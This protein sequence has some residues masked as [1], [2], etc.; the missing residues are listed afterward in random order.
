MFWMGNCIYFWS[1]LAPRAV[2]ATYPPYHSRMAG[3]HACVSGSVYM[4]SLGVRVGN[5]GP[6]LQ[7]LRS[8]SW[9]LIAASNCG[10]ADTEMRR[11]RCNPHYHHFCKTLR[12]LLK[13][14]P[15]DLKIR[16]LFFSPFIFFFFLWEADKVWDIQKQPYVKESLES[17]CTCSRKVQAFVYHI[18]ALNPV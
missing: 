2:V 3:S 16:C 8:I 7:I 6:I 17:H 13:W 14:L 9:L 4:H 12:F 15:G 5:K 1:I 11:Y 18:S 10:D